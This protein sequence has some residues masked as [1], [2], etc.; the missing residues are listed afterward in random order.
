MA[1]EL[2]LGSTLP[3]LLAEKKREKILRCFLFCYCFVVFPCPGNETFMKRSGES[4]LS[5]S[6]L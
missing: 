5:A 3:V 1:A 6:G 2:F 4:V